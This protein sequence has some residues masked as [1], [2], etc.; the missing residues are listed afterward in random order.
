[1]LSRLCLSALM[2]F[3][4]HA[5]AQ[6]PAGRWYVHGSGGQMH[7]SADSTIDGSA[8]TAFG[9][10]QI[11]GAES[12][13]STS[14]SIGG[15]YRFTK[16]LALEVAYIDL[17]ELHHQNNAYSNGATLPA[18]DG[19]ISRKW[20]AA[21]LEITALGAWPISSSFDLLAKGS[22]YALKGKYR[23]DSRAAQGGT[24]LFSSSDSA[25]GSGTVP[26]I[27]AGVRYA[28]TEQLSVRAIYEVWAD[29][30]GMFGSSANDLKDLRL[31]TLGLQY[32]F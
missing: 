27:G 28:V 10:A 7:S 8:V 22:L 21:G 23:T 9:V 29:K 25:S 11:G 3:A 31:F 20:E 4:A 5:A 1:M 13:S 17:G 30:S 26:A 2:L 12:S 16:H 24:V 15:G 6:A 32:Q 14:F 18:R 19:A